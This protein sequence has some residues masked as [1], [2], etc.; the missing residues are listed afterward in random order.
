MY[1]P[2][3]V[4]RHVGSALSGRGSDFSI[5]HGHRNLV[6]TF[7]KNMPPVLLA[8]YWLHHLAVNLI[9]ITHFLSH[10][11]GATILRAKR[12]ALK[13]MP[14]ILRARRVIQ[15]RRRARSSELRRF[16]VGGQRSLGRRMA[17]TD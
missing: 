13:A 15:A 6:W 14:R 16:M 9:S 5:Y 1:V 3:A 10:G 11:H 4:V 8:I 12:D 17:S 7:W 2:D